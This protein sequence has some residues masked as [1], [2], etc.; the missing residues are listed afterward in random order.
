[1]SHVK[2]GSMTRTLVGFALIVGLLVAPAWAAEI[3]PGVQKEIDKHIEVVKGWAADPVIVKAVAAQNEMG[4]LPGVDNAKWK[5]IRRSEDTIKAFQNGPA[6]QYLTQKVKGSNETF[7]EAFLSAAQGEKV[8]FVEKTT[9]YIH[10]GQPKFD[11]PFGNGGVWQGK[12]EFDESSQTHQVQ[13]SVPVL[14]G[15]KAVGVLVVGLNVT[16]LEKTAQK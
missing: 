16:K 3:T 1:M 6:G 14:S 8:A 12:P 2:E 11:V 9:S 10:K 7:S 13:V 15:G 4:P 5:T